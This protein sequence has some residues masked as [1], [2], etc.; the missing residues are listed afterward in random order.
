MY[1]VLTNSSPY[2]AIYNN[3]IQLR[4]NLSEFLD[5]YKDHF[6]YANINYRNMSFNEI[7]LF[8]IQIGQKVINENM[9]Y[10][11]IQIIKGMP[12]ENLPELQ[13][14]NVDSVFATPINEMDVS[15]SRELKNET[16]VILQTREMDESEF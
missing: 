11:I 6:E 9:N 12:F 14:N 13:M 16:I 4:D 8:A 5:I 1:I 7:V 3:E 2:F 10:G 15:G